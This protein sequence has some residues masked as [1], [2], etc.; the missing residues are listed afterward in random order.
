MEKDISSGAEKVERVNSAAKAREEAQAAE[1]EA[2]DARYRAAKAREEVQR[3]ERA[4]EQS[5]RGKQKAE[6]ALRKEEKARER[7]ARRAR[8]AREKAAQKQKRREER[9][10]RRQARSQGG[11]RRRAPG[12]GGWI[13]AVSVLGAACLAL[14]TVVTVGSFRM[15]DMAKSSANAF[16]AALYE[17]VSV[18]ENMDDNLAK[19]RIASGAAE[20][21][22]LLTEI[23]VDTAI[24]ESAIEKF[25]VDEAT[26]TDM[27]AFV[28]RTGMGAR[29]MLRAL[30]AGR[31]LQEFD[32]EAIARFYETNARLCA[33]LNDLV[34]HLPEKELARFLAGKGSMIGDRLSDLGHGAAKK[35]EEPVPPAG[36]GENVAKSVAE[37]SAAR[38]EERVRKIFK[39]YHVADVRLTGETM[40][41]GVRAYNFTLTDEGGAEFFA[42]VSKDGGRL[43]FF[44]S[45]ERCT[46]KNFS[47]E[48]CDALAREFL[49]SAGYAQLVPVWF[50]E[51]GNVA[52]VTYVA[53]KD[54]VRLYSDLIRVRVCEQKG[55]VVGMDARTYGLRPHGTR[56]TVPTLSR[57]EACGRLSPELRAESVH[58][59]LIPLGR[60]EVLTYECACR[61][62]E[63]EFL[64]YLDAH[65]G[66]EV[67][68]YRV[69]D[70]AQGRYLA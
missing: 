12:I 69:H 21:R 49:A 7:Q 64:V 50:S 6:R 34:R 10:A 8:E 19:L 26:G 38:A 65:T 18:S 63:E 30:A 61:F 32:R 66:E 45:Y 37:V 23:L 5:A 44:D 68:I 25:P 59:A 58:L 3:A 55:R 36:E 35:P 1:R 53:E 13:A 46:Q 41:R 27:S 54:G 22:L 67:R 11:G 51:A 43:L 42:Q 48:N 29:R 15:T 17:L 4:N 39:G 2:A 62:G 70:S 60:R 52:S 40:S 24:M 57:E 31:A 14:A 9:A 16:R 28:N 56:D 47:L 33:E 20:Q